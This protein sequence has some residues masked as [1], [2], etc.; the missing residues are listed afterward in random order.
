MTNISLG[1]KSNNGEKLLYNNVITSPYKIQR[2]LI[3][4]YIVR[5]VKI[6]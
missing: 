2:V 3:S 1:E 6:I 5:I 4:I